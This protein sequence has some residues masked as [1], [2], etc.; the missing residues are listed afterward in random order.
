MF[1]KPSI[2]AVT[3]GL[4]ATLEVQVQCRNAV[5]LS[6]SSPASMSGTFL[7]GPEGLPLIKFGS[8]ERTE[9][10][11]VQLTFSAVCLLR[12]STSGSRQS[13]S[14]LHSSNWKNVAR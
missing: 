11:E 2:E 6:L 8:L 3:V 1:V 9:K 14:L 13:K 5:S 4:L 7:A 10:S 12:F